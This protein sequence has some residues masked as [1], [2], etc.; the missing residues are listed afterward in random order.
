VNQLLHHVQTKEINHKNV[1]SQP[2]HFPSKHELPLSYVI[3]AVTILWS[4][5][6]LFLKHLSPVLVVSKDFLH[7]VSSL[8][9]PQSNVSSVS[10]VNFLSGFL[11]AIT[12]FSAYCP[13]SRY[14]VQLEL[15]LLKTCDNIF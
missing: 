8:A 15:V 10:A 5:V 7:E 14:F 9:P 11:L 3:S 1:F 2:D 12:L 6:Q 13:Q 4:F